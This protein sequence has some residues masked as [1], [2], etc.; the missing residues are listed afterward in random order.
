VVNIV[1]AE[2]YSEEKIKIIQD[3]ILSKQTIQV[4]N[5]ILEKI[6][7]LHCFTWGG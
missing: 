3:T 7:E 2:E 4:D 6:Q 1:N 5:S